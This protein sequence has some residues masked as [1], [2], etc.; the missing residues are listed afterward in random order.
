MAE[1]TKPLYPTIITATELDELTGC[2]LSKSRAMEIKNKV[3]ELKH[4]LKHYKKCRNRW[5]KANR[6]IHGLGV[7]VGLAVGGTAAAVGIVG[8]SGVLIP[9]AVPI[10]LASVGAIETVI[11]E[12]V[13]FA[14]IKRK[15]HK[16]GEKVNLVSLFVNRMYLL[17]H[18]AIEDKKI[19]LEEIEEFQSL[20]KEYENE[21][22]KMSTWDTGSDLDKTILRKLQHKAEVAAREECE[23][24]LLAK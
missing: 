13:A 3:N 16:F 8:T 20:V 21:M 1:I 24:E 9:I 10:T 18:R 12:S 6:I 17:Y 7:G 14:L 5:K 4:K 19:T 11:T 22:S 23:T 15:I 2:K